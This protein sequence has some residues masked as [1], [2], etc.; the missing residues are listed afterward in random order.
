[1]RSDRRVLHTRKGL[2]TMA[3]ANELHD[4]INRYI[5]DAIAAEQANITGLKDMISESTDPQDT[6]LFQEHL[7]QTENQRGRLEQ[8]LQALGGHHNGVKD[9]VNRLGM[10]ATDLLHAG[11]DAGDKATRNLIQAYSI[12]NMEVAMYESL[13]AAASEAGDAETEALAKEIQYEEELTAKK[14]F[15]RISQMARIAVQAES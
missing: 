2:N 12:E 1:M 7:A 15:P 11:K 14:I 3:A 6:S 9:V 8:R 13:A 4:R 10:A 5:D